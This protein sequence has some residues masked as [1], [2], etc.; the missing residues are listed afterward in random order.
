MRRLR[1]LDENE[2][3]ARLYGEGDR[4][5]RIVKLER[6]RPRVIAAMD[7]EELRRRFAQL[8]DAR[9]PDEEAEAA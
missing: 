4:T 6:R 8:L 1:A 7:G 5:V 3:Y 2:C 9:E